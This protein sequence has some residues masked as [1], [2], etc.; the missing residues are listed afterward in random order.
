MT[1]VRLTAFGLLQAARG[2]GITSPPHEEHPELWHLSGFQPGSKRLE[3][4]LRK[5]VTLTPKP[6][7]REEICP[8]AK[9]L[10]ASEHAPSG[11]RVSTHA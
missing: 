7:E 4:H 10:E 5:P 1:A 6:A 3:R 8:K 11:I 2:G 9:V